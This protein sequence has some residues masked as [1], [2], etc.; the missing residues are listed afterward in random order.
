M[1]KIRFATP[2]IAEIV[3]KK[4]HAPVEHE[5]VG[6]GYYA[7]PEIEFFIMVPASAEKS[8]RKYARKFTY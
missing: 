5:Y 6:E 1:K 4:F 2:A 7:Y 3:G 8:A